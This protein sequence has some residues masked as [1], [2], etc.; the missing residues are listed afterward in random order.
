MTSILR[1]FILA[2]LLS[3]FTLLGAIPV[4]AD[5]VVEGDTTF[6]FDLY[7]QL[8]SAPG[9][10]FFS[11]Y[12]ISTAL[13]MTYAGAWGDT[14]KQMRQVLHFGDSQEQLHAS[15]AK[16]QHQLGEAGKQNGIELDLANALWA[17]KGYPFLPAFLKTA[18]NDYQASV[19]QADF[20][21][22]A[23]AA[24]GEI[25][26]WVE[27]RTRER[28]QDIL[29]AGSIDASTRLVLANA[30]YFKGAWVKAY[31]P[32]ET[33]TQ[34]FHLSRTHQT[35]VP[36][37]HHFDEVRYTESAEFQAVELPYKGEELAMV[38]LL[39]RELE[40][41]GTLE[42]RLNPGLL[43]TSL[44]EMK[45]QKVEIFLP[46]FKLE[47]SSDL[48]APLTRMGMPDAFA[49]EANFSGMDAKRSLYISAVFHKA[50]GEVNEEGTEAA[51]ATAVVTMLSSAPRP[52]PPRPVF[53]ADHPF[54]FLIRDTKS[55]SLLFLGRFAEPG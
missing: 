44:K 40:G 22:G 55:G 51:A 33:S 27:Q 54:I 30:I 50:W 17:Q 11:P 41:C 9:N 45:K 34:P 12:S 14:E 48:V 15:F 24:R 37:M 36:L 3:V 16:L 31:E 10:L 18:R 23:E 26:R 38:I 19:Q 32:D 46:R 43:S 13:A 5:S 39:P 49:A 52:V 25:N 1:K 4:R 8:K 47:T 42:S 2:L 29:P 6:A 7:G 35:D 20:T 21:T 28:I 53:R